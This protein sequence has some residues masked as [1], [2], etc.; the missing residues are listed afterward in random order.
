MI[1]DLLRTGPSAK[2]EG[3][4]KS[5]KTVA[6]VLGMLID[7]LGQFTEYD[8]QIETKLHDLLV[9]QYQPRQ[10][11]L[12]DPRPYHGALPEWG[13]PTKVEVI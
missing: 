7:G 11:L 4:L 13:T 6:D 2:L 9:E 8:R 5:C 3:D 1:P 12:L 10:E